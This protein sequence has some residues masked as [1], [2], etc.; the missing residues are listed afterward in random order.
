VSE[1]VSDMSGLLAH[2]QQMQQQLVDAQ[3]AIASTEVTG[4]AGGGLVTARITGS[5]ELIGLSIDPRVVESGPP[6][7]VADAIADLV[8]AAVRNANQDAD[9]LRAEAM[10]PIADALGGLRLP[11]RTGT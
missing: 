2:A 8:L 4:S 7:Q 5:G 9:E 6:A 10:S 11:G 3:E 1:S